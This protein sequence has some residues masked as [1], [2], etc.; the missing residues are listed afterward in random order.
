MKHS[1]WIQHFFISFLLL[2]LMA[3]CATDSTQ[4]STDQYLHDSAITS[5]VKQKLSSDPDLKN[6]Q[7]NVETRSGVVQLSGFVNSTKASIK[8]EE[9]ARSVKDVSQVKNHLIVKGSG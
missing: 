7:I 9:L 6:L 2:V 1:I 8:A 3:G 4:K 5:A